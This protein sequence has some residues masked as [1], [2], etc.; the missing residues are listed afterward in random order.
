MIMSEKLIGKSI[1]VLLLIIFLI[2][3]YTAN[4]QSMYKIDVNAFDPQVIEIVKSYIQKNDSTSSFLLLTYDNFISKI[5]DSYLDGC[6]FIIGP[7]IKGIINENPSVEKDL[8]GFDIVKDD[9]EKG[10]SAI[11]KYPTLYFS[12]GEHDVYIQSSL[13]KLLSN[14]GTGLS[15]NIQ[16]DNPISRYL[17]CS[18]VVEKVLVNKEI[19][20]QVNNS[21]KSDFPMEIGN[22]S[23]DI[24]FKP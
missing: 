13:D 24:Q 19:R 15:S 16:R 21:L 17:E 23:S 7:Y 4:S 18:E 12:I 8:W 11:N 9:M 14:N 6:C 5:K 1:R 2:K 10:I 3:G 20:F 22:I